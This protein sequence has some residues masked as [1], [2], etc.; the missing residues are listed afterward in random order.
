MIEVVNLDR[1][2]QILLM[3]T[4]LRNS[5]LKSKLQGV[6]DSL[7]DACEAIIKLV[8]NGDKKHTPVHHLVKDESRVLLYRGIKLIGT[9]DINNTGGVGTDTYN[10]VHRLVLILNDLSDF[11]GIS[12]QIF[13]IPF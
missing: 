2:K 11:I 7:Y 6:S 13:L 10:A 8:N 9:V 1:R 4:V 12:W 3:G 5:D